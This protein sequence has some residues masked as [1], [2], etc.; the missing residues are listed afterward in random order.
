MFFC[1]F[2][3]H[4]SDCE[5]FFLMI[6]LP[7]R[8]TRTYTL[9]PYTT[10]FRSHHREVGKGAEIGEIEAA[11]VGLPGRADQPRP[12]HRETHRQVLDGDVVDD[13]VEIGRAHV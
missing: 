4:Y 13:L 6:R 11:G 8:S 1:L 3:C 12:V 2:L 10:L 5:M 7:P 9:F